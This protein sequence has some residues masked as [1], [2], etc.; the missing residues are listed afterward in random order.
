MPAFR[1]VQK[2]GA[3]N[4]WRLSDKKS[5]WQLASLACMKIVALIKTY[6]LFL[7][8][9]VALESVTVINCIKKQYCYA[10]DYPY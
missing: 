5:C 4:D 2:A 10:Q 6:G 8:L 3:V 7:Q 9:A 1:R